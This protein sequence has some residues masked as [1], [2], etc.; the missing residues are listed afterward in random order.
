MGRLPLSRLILCASAHDASATC[1]SGWIT[2]ARPLRP[3]NS[4]VYRIATDNGF[5][6]FLKHPRSVILMRL[7]KPKVQFG[8]L[9]PRAALLW[10]RGDPQ[11]QHAHTQPAGDHQE[12][13]AVEQ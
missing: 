12:V 2:S 11:A 6:S 13:D 1:A 10:Q 3:V 5:L 8:S 9:A 7:L 4:A